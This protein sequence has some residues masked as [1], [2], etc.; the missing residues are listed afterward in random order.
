MAIETPAHDTD[1]DRQLAEGLG[2]SRTLTVGRDRVA[3]RSS[4]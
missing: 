4:L 2:R 1:S 3:D